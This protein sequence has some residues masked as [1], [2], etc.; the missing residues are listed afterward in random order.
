LSS[1]YHHG[2]SVEWIGDVDGDEIDDYAAS[3]AGRSRVEVY[4]G[5]SKTSI[6][7][8]SGGVRHGHSLTRIGDINW[9]G[10][11]EFAAGTP[12]VNSN[13]GEVRVYS[14]ADFSVLYTLSGQQ[15]GDYF[16]WGLSSLGDTDNDGIP[17]FLVRSYK[18]QGVVSVH[19]GVDGAKQFEIR[20]ATAY[21]YIG[22]GLAGIHDYNGDG[23]ADFLVG[24][25]GRGNG[26]VVL[27]SG[28]NGAVLSSF[29]DASTREFGAAVCMLGDLTGDQVP[30][31]A[32][33]APATTQL[34]QSHAGEVRIYNGQTLNEIRQIQGKAASDRFGQLLASGGDY[35]QD[36]YADFLVAAPGADANGLHSPG[37]VELYSG[38]SFSVLGS[39]AGTQ[40][41]ERMPSSLAG[42]GDAHHDLHPDYL[43]G[44]Y[45][46]G[47]GER[48]I[49]R[50]WG[51]PSAWLQVNNLVGGQMATLQATECKGGS[52]VDFWASL[53]GNGPSPTP[54]GLALLS[55]PFRDLGSATASPSGVA[56]LSRNVPIALSGQRVY[57]QAVE[58]R[59]G[60]SARLTTATNQV[61][62]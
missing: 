28:A 33:G 36:G 40:Q 54:L 15:S 46:Y 2:F 52:R 39:V 16:G 61:I 45:A 6:A 43:L 48:G 41:H 44:N 34:G 25:P 51:A 21:E 19:S 59:P 42:P 3:T 26:E 37:L 55:P 17:D 38:A 5:D 56:L 10:I 20:P 57:F 18:V 50:M 53:Q 35:N 27:H 14:G 22:E 24:A 7:T 23:A 9:D 4:S 8:L 11:P 47:S 60:L 31:F 58:F 30:E 32:I 1:Y 29:S 12:Y 49:V 62:Q 13:M